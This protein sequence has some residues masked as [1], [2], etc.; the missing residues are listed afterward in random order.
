MPIL[1][2]YNAKI[3]LRGGADTTISVQASSYPSAKQLVLAQYPNSTILSLQQVLKP[4]VQPAPH[5]ANEFHLRSSSSSKSPKY[6]EAEDEEENYHSYV[7]RRPSALRNVFRWVVRLVI[8]F[9]ILVLSLAV[10]GFYINSHQPSPL[11]GP[12]VPVPQP[13]SDK[14]TTSF[15]QGVDARRKW[16]NWLDSISSDE[17]KG[18]VY[19]AGE[20]SKATPGTC[21]GSADFAAGCFQ[22]MK[23]LMIVD[24]RRRTDQNYRRGWNHQ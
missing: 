13:T 19:W 24:T 21:D 14:N 10:L 20:R 12:A 7:R 15:L 1:R 23:R 5:K 8:I 11:T 18:A 22:A 2:E 4:Y 6:D 16:E 3:R 9:T 17:K